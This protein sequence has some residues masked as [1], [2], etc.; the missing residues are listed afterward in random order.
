MVSHLI[1]VNCFFLIID[2]C[3]PTDT[4]TKIDCS[5]K[6]YKHAQQNEREKTK[7]RKKRDCGAFERS[8]EVLGPLEERK[9]EN[10]QYLKK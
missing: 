10:R 6:H 1:C 2:L 3:F 7:T 9:E 4:S 5:K 8:N